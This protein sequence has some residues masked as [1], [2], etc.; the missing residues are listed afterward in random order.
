MGLALLQI[1]DSNNGDVLLN[2]ELNLFDIILNLCSKLYHEVLLK[3]GNCI[4]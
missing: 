4:Y 2:S 3:S 1:L